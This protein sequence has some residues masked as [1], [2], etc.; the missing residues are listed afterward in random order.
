MANREELP[1]KT[2]S[3]TFWFVATG[4]CVVTLSAALATKASALPAN[5]AQYRA[6]VNAICRSY[7]PRLK[8][9]EAA[10]SSARAAGDAHRYA[11]DIGVLVGI[12]LA[13]GVR[14]EKTPVPSDAATRMARP[15]RL[16][17]L[18]DAQLRRIVARA[19]AGDLRGV[20]AQAAPLAKLQRPL[21]ASFDAVGL[22]DCGSTQS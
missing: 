5:A 2:A 14:I 1:I 8:R 7:T 11:Y 18:V 17:H 16:L 10:A 19:L 21:N 6:H 4:V 13:E 9:V 3:R 22:R 15:L 20:L 12:T